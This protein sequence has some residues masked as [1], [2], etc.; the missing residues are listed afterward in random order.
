MVLCYCK[1]LFTGEL[2]RTEEWKIFKLSHD[3]YDIFEETLKNQPA[4]WEYVSKLRYDYNAERSVL[5]LRMPTFIHENAVSIVNHKIMAQLNSYGQQYP[6]LQPHIE[7][8]C[9]D[10]ADVSLKLEEN[11]TRSKTQPDIGFRQLQSGAPSLVIEVAYSQTSKSLEQVAE[12]HI[13][14]SRGA[15]RTVIGIDIDYPRGLRAFWSKWLMV[16]DADEDGGT[17]TASLAIDKQVCTR[18][19]ACFRPRHATALL[20]SSRRSSIMYHW[21]TFHTRK[22]S[23]PEYFPRSNDLSSLQMFRDQDGSPVPNLS[24][25]LKLSDFFPRGLL[26]EISTY[27][28]L[29][30]TVSSEKLCEL[31][32]L[33][34]MFDDEI[35]G[36]KGKRTFSER[37]VASTNAEDTL[38][39]ILSSPAVFTL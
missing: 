28:D 5:I 6:A 27:A 21:S 25:N 4:L 30:V 7:K 26:P 16:Y 20:S 22:S 3:D 24:L 23:R 19:S 31:L 9:I 34:R 36:V 32:G 11:D 12:N 29:E 17:I 1:Q 35:P 13:L 14:G 8:L 18:G 39:T 37:T 2:E 33:E 38:C 10:S 15:I